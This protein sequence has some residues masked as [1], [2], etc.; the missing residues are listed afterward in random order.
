MVQKDA[1]QGD[2]T[3]VNAADQPAAYTVQDRWLKMPMAEYIAG[4]RDF[5][6]VRGYCPAAT[7]KAS[8]PPSRPSAST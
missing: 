3:Q 8:A 1:T 7:P 4:Y 5:G 6:R 2:M